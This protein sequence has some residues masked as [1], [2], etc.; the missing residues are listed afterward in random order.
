MTVR[1]LEKKS[2]R[3]MKRE[4]DKRAASAEVRADTFVPLWPQKREPCG[5]DLTNASPKLNLPV[6]KPNV[7]PK[8][9]GLSACGKR[10]L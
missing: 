2:R 5:A 3:K 10:N 4:L 7:S 1:R 9:D 6:K 8:T